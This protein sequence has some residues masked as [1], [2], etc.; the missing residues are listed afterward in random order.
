MSAPALLSCLGISGWGPLHLWLPGRSAPEPLL[1]RLLRARRPLQGPGVSRIPPARLLASLLRQEEDLEPLPVPIPLRRLQRL[2]FRHR[3]VCPPGEPRLLLRS[4]SRSG[5]QWLAC[6]PERRID[7]GLI[8]VGRA[9][10]RAVRA[11]VSRQEAAG[12]AESESRCIASLRSQSTQSQGLLS[13][14]APPHDEGD[15][16]RRE[17]GH[18]ISFASPPVTCLQLPVS[19]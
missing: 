13:D 3:L 15:P 1:Q 10:I 11:P 12:L 16:S 7:A 4:W 18:Q 8:A 2:Q 5:G 14:L 6:G 17:P 9:G 19:R